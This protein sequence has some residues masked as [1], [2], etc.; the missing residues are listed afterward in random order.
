MATDLE[1]SA[2]Q[3]AAHRAYTRPPQP[4]VLLVE[5][6]V[7]VMAIGLIVIGTIAAAGTAETV[8]P[9]AIYIAGIG[10]IIAGLAI[11]LI[12][13]VTRRLRRISDLIEEQRGHFDERLTHSK[14][15][16]S[17]IITLICELL[18]IVQPGDEVGERRRRPR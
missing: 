18:G 7:T 11:I 9:E 10:A 5:L 13:Y 2:P 4:T 8:G 12:Q 16:D 1:S 17:E 6:A 15:R 14:T 3:P